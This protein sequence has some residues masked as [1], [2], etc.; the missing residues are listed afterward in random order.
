MK[1]DPTTFIREFE[2]FCQS[3]T[4]FDLGDRGA[5]RREI[6]YFI[7]PLIDK[8]FSPKKPKQHDPQRLE[9]LYTLISN[10]NALSA[11]SELKS[12][13]DEYTIFDLKRKTQES[14]L[15]GV[16]RMTAVYIGDCT[17]REMDT[18]EKL[19][20][21]QEDLSLTKRINEGMKDSIGPATV[22]FS[23][24]G[25]SL[26]TVTEA[27]ERRLKAIVATIDTIYQDYQQENYL[28]VGSHLTTQ[29]KRRIVYE[30]LSRA[31]ESVA[32]RVSTTLPMLFLDDDGFT[33]E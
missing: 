21:L 1:Y 33:D 4:H 24:H 27:T 15:Y 11:V 16:R 26:H 22:A 8:R 2:D 13:G 3:C 25:A 20:S 9:E 10:L 6:S 30:S 32:E 18:K 29:S 12:S 19:K 23:N 31:M 5:G 28:D 17:Q 7:Y 14:P